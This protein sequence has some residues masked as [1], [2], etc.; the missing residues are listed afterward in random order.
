MCSLSH[1]QLI[2]VELFGFKRH[3]EFL[4]R[5]TWFDWGHRCDT[6]HTNSITYYA[7]THTQARRLSFRYRKPATWK[8]RIND[9]ASNSEEKKSVVLN[10]FS[11][12]SIDIEN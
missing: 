12:N 7:R 1:I 6:Y 10:Q 5:K 11:F 3:T 9:E 8:I 4:L 2:Q